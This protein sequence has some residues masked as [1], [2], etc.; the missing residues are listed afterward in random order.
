MYLTCF[1]RLYCGF[2]RFLR[3]FLLSVVPVVPRG[4]VYTNCPF[5]EFDQ[6]KLQSRKA[7]IF[8][9]HR[10]FPGLKD[11]CEHHRRPGMSCTEITVKAQVM[12]DGQGLT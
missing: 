9:S 1:S 7:S 5:A 3:E 10:I 4:A 6:A 8:N 2:L 12:T 11:A